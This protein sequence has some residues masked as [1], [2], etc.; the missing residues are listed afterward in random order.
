MHKNENMRRKEITKI[1]NDH[2]TGGGF[3]PKEFKSS[4]SKK[5]NPSAEKLSNEQMH[6]NAI[7]GGGVVMPINKTLDKNSQTSIEMNKMTSTERIVMNDIVSRE[8]R[9]GCRLEIKNIFLFILTH[10]FKINF[11]S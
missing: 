4:R 6:E 2:E 7:F 5:Q 11:F 1:D 9:D 8:N 10:L 3:V